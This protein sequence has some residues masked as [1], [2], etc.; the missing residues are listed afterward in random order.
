MK[1]KKSISGLYMCAEKKKNKMTDK[2]INEDITYDVH[3]TKG[4]KVRQLV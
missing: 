2:E 3:T 1:K 4:I